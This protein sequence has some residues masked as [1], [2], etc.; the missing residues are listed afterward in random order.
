MTQGTPLYFWLEKGRQIV[1]EWNWEDSTDDRIA[2]QQ[3]AATWSADTKWDNSAQVTQCLKRDIS[4][5]EKDPGNVLSA[6]PITDNG[7]PK[8]FDTEPLYSKSIPVPLA[9]LPR[10]PEDYP[11]PGDIMRSAPPFDGP[12]KRSLEDEVEGVCVRAVEDD[13]KRRKVVLDEGEGTAGP[14]QPQEQQRVATRSMGSSTRGRGR[15]KR[16]TTV[17]GKAHR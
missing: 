1:K 2:F 5:K 14:G 16:K 7:P 10:R 8:A 17:T 9:Q 12:T 15:R 4:E 6:T 11:L 3:F 13:K